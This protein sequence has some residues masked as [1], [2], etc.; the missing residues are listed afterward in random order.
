MRSFLIDTDTASDDAVALVMALRHR[1]IKVEA[2]TVVA[3]N[4][5]LDMA[6]Q[7]ALYTRELC[8]ADDVPVYAGCALPMLQAVERAHIVH[9]SDGMGDIDLP[10]SGRVPNDGHAVDVIIEMAH[11]FEGALTL[12]TL[13]PLTNVALA[14]LRDP[15]IATMFERCVVMGGQG[16]GPGNSTPLAEFNI[17][18]DPEALAIVL[19][20]GLECTFVGWDI[21]TGYATIE[22]ETNARLRAV[23]TPLAHFCV[24][25]QRQVDIFAR[26]WSKLAGYDLPDPVA[27]AVALEPSIA[28][29][30]HRHV[31]VIWGDVYA[32][33]QL[34]ID[35]LQNQEKEPNAYVCQSVDRERF[36]Q[37]LEESFAV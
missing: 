6:V 30:A 12:V 9:G 35:W 32:K 36:L 28:V 17:Y 3:G 24:D 23:G 1:D 37:M 11:R 10:L 20:S 22:P 25:I 15:S 5:P 13:G 16:A 21:S 33:G 27:M 31:G 34:V 29:L 8:G 2:I 19:A 14:L 18:C 4:V 26:E 7:N